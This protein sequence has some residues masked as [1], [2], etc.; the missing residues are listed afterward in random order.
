MYASSLRQ[1][2]QRPMEPKT[3][4]VDVVYPTNNDRTAA[5]LAPTDS[6]ADMGLYLQYILPCL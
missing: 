1:G 2:N 3:L 4:L 6:I 5:F